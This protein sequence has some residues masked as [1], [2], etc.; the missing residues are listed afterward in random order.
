[1]KTILMK[2][3]LILLLL[4]ISFG[5][6]HTPVYAADDVSNYT[7]LRQIDKQTFNEYRYKITEQFFSLRDTFDVEGTIDGATARNIAS[8][9]EMSYKY[10][11][12]NL[13]NKNYLQALGT[14]LRKGLKFPDNEA[15]YTSLV[16]AISNYLEKVDIQ[17]LKWSIQAIPIKGNAPLT[18]TLRW[19]VNDPT[20]ASIPNFN[21]VWFMNKAGNRV[22]LGRWQSLTYTFVEEGNFSVFL[23]VVSSHKNEAWFTDVLPFSS[24]VDIQVEE[25]IASVIIKVNGTSLR[26]N[27]VLKFT[28][29]EARYGLIFDATSSTPTSGTKFLSTEW[30]FWNGTERDYRDEPRVE[31]VKYAWEWDYEVKLKLKTND[32][33]TIERKFTV[34]IFDPIATVE[35]SQ[36]EGFIGDKF[37]FK[38]KPGWNEKDLSYA[39]EIIDIDNDKIVFNK[40]GKNFNYT[41]LNKGKFNVKLTVT[42]P[43][44]DV[45]IDTKIVYINS[46]APVA[47][48][49]HTIPQ[50]NKPNTVFLDASKS[51]DA[52]FTDDGKLT[53]SWYINGNKLNLDKANAQGS[54]GYYT[55]DSI[56]SQSVNLEVT[57]PDGI[58]S[59]KKQDVQIKSLLAVEV[60]AFPRVI[61]RE[62]F[63]KFV[64]EAPTADIFEWDFG[65][66][67]QTWGTSETITHT[68]NKSGTFDVKLKVT[69]PD[70][71]T[72]TYQK[73]VYVWESD[74]PVAITDVSMNTEEKPDFQASAC[75][76]KGGYIIDRTSNMKFDA[77]ESINIDGTTK[78]LTYSWRVGNSKFSS[79][80]NVSHKFDELGCFP[81][82]LTV[83]SNE[84]WKTDTELLWMDVRNT[85]PELTSLNIDLTNPDGDPLVVNVSA[86]WAEDPD[87]VIQSYL[88]YY[89]T[90]IDTEPQDFR[91]TTKPNTT[92]VLPKITGNYYFVAILKDNNEEKVNSEEITDSKFFIT[93]TGDNIDTPLVDLSVNDSALSIAEEVIYTAAAKNVLGQDLSKKVKYSWDF[94]G[95]GFYD[96]ETTTPSVTHKFDTSGT[97][98][99][100]VKIKHK[101]ISSTKTV[102]LNVSNVLTPDFRYISIGNKM[103]FFDTS[104]G[105]VESISWDLWDGNTQ[106]D[107][108][109]THTYSD[110]KNSHKVTLKIS[111][112]TKTKEITKT[113]VRNMK[114]VLTSRRAGLNVFTYPFV[115]DGVITLTEKGESVFIYSGDSNGEIES[116]AIDYDLTVD[117]NLNGW[118]DDDE[119]NKWTSGYLDGSLSKVEL[120][121]ARNQTIRVFIKD[122]AGTV[123][124]SE[125]I[126]ILKTYVKEVEEIDPSTIEFDGV[127]TIEK[128][129]IDR[130]KTLLSGLEQTQRV[131]AMSYVQKLQEEWFDDTEKTRVIIDFEL[132]LDENTPDIA[133]EA[134]ELL[135]SLLVEWQEDKS[136][137]NISLNALKNLVPE[138]IVCEQ[139][140]SFASCYEY[141]MGTLESIKDS[142]SLEDNKTLGSEVLTILGWVENMTN[143]QKLDF[144]A[145]LK[146]LVYGSVDDIPEEE[147]QDAINDG[148]E[149]KKESW[150]LIDILSTVLYWVGV[151][152]FVF[153]LVAIAYF[154]YY[155]IANKDDSVGFTD[156]IKKKTAADDI[157]ADDSDILSDLGW[158]IE[159]NKQNDT[160]DILSVMPESVENKAASAPKVEEKVELPSKTNDAGVPDWLAGNFDDEPVA[161]TVVEKQPETPK[162]EEKKPEPKAP[163]VKTEETGDVPSWLAWVSELTDT[164]KKSEGKKE[165]KPVGEKKEDKAPEIKSEVKTDEKEADVPDWLKTSDEK[166]NPSV[167][168][169]ADT[170]KKVYK[171]PDEQLITDENIDAVTSLND[172][173]V[174][175]WLKQD[176]SKIEGVESKKKK[177]DAKAA[178]KRQKAKK[179]SDTKTTA[180]LDSD[181]VKKTT[182]PHLPDWLADSFVDDTSAKTS[183]EKEAPVKPAATKSPNKK[184]AVKKTETKTPTK[185]TPVKK[186]VAKTDKKTTTDSKK[187]PAAKPDTKK[188]SAELWDDGMEVPDWLKS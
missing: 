177:T 1:M 183:K 182:D 185:K 13:K 144:K 124:D 147:K 45:D 162:V 138:D 37:T 175:S 51:Y 178:P 32:L 187:T 105:Q 135:S 52:D 176:F 150:K 16:Q 20:G 159:D 108:N 96:K 181:G 119:D 141:L 42:E 100:K 111:E 157:E 104:K 121:S 68:Y 79:S 43:S 27:T 89:Y 164:D 35:S 122:E 63:I 93:V 70:G 76:G 22:E 67:K 142:E 180:K 71:N 107:S 116:Y 60:F 134:I 21:Y 179:K 87:G 184:P 125:D 46:R 12:D 173:E 133:D 24:R 132:Y 160:S 136:S 118:K 102:T 73:T 120:N 99:S 153:F 140:S 94:D 145:I 36:D 3:L 84:N 146:S 171:I 33:K 50:T 95:D 34:S 17:S 61:Q 174:P 129:K 113:V 78:D 114:N 139:P 155:K 137:R 44:G 83:K 38:A 55:F 151:F 58:S 47:A 14:E 30:D 103:I 8:L 31:R 143:A 9:A 148:S 98:H 163:D 66:G 106:T 169:Q 152:L 123:I 10:L 74:V 59:L 18:V 62:W 48:F 101:G 149:D 15:N 7:T 158:I 19:K 170:T 112:G 165:E 81:V 154:I 130:L 39:W 131:E 29:A 90:D 117:A 86:Q 186:S 91:S 49:S 110:G 53:Y 161:A 11:P 4:A 85:L 168:K 188:D 40:S 28:P 109:F 6:M 77:K 26:N 5:A 54:N 65:D 166:P 172:D 97:F 25:K 115:E 23:E 82:K 92:F 156:F 75:N 41:F 56:W 64:A 88:W 69:D 57:D 2:K 128:E 126:E 80:I 72:N 167:K 127:S